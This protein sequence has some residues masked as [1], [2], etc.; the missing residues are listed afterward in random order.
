MLRKKKKKAKKPQLH[1]RH[2]NH[3]Q[4]QHLKENDS[5]FQKKLQK[6]VKTLFSDNKHNLKSQKRMREKIALVTE[7]KR[8]KETA[9]QQ[10]QAKKTATKQQDDDASDNEDA[11]DEAAEDE[12]Q[13]DTNA[14]LVAAEKAAA[15]PSLFCELVKDNK[16]PER[17]V[18]TLSSQISPNNSV[19]HRYTFFKK[20]AGKMKTRH[21]FTSVF[22]KR[23]LGDAQEDESMKLENT[24]DKTIFVMNPTFN[25][26][27]NRDLTRS[28]EQFGNIVSMHFGVRH[29]Y[30][31]FEFCWFFVQC[32][33]PLLFCFMC[34]FP[35]FF[36]F[37]FSTIR[38]LQ[39]SMKRS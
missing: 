33:S 23:L 24:A 17:K 34:F 25:A 7:A 19:F 18:V 27:S 1:E 35:P 32:N 28:F 4:H 16:K 21:N 9:Q 39:L 30:I 3:P 10:Q 11:E 12:D 15:F 5:E 6:K 2:N 8:Q 37:V 31:Y 29:T 20:H 36:D 13:A 26:Q 38:I 22:N 14:K